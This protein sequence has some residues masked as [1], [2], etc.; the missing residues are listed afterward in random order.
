MLCDEVVDIA[1]KLQASIVLNFVDSDCC[2]C[3]EFLD[4]I[5]VE[6]ITG[7]VLAGEIKNVSFKYGLDFQNC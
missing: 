1:C 7:E 3:E 5:N 6:R 2:I 4:F